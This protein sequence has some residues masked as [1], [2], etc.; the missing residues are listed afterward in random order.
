VLT[1]KDVKLILLALSPIL[2]ALL[3]WGALV[4]ILRT[5]YPLL[6]VK[7]G[8]MEPTLHDGDLVLIQ[9]V[10]VEEVQV[11]DIVAFFKPGGHSEIIIHR[12][13]DKVEVDGQ[14]LL[15]TKGDNNS[16]PDKDLVGP[17]DLLGRMIYRLPGVGNAIRFLKSPVGI[18]IIAVVYGVFLALLFRS[19]EEG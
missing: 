17:E 16:F 7:G 9:G 1:R 4:A 13:I 18:A 5:P 8:S 2:G 12:V 15:E 10:S 19:P 3:I 6:I 11:G 14:V